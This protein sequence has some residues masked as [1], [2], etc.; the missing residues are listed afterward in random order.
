[1]CWL[2]VLHI[3]VRSPP[4]YIKA[5]SG[6]DS[7]WLQSADF[8]TC[9]AHAI[10]VSKLIQTILRDTGNV[11]EFPLFLPMAVLRAGWIHALALNHIRASSNS[12]LESEE[13]ERVVRLL[14]EDTAACLNALEFGGKLWRH[15][16]QAYA[17]FAGIVLAGVFPSADELDAL[18]GFN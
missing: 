13:T 11:L 1:M 7:V 15:A 4:D 17:I 3:L 14:V 2:H 8:V 18:R 12:I 5:L 10:T 6:P 16:K 9:S